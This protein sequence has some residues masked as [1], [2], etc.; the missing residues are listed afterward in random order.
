MPRLAFRVFTFLMGSFANREPGYESPGS[1]L[2]KA[3]GGVGFLEDGHGKTRTNSLLAFYWPPSGLVV[4][5]QRVI[6]RHRL[7]LPLFLAL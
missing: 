2:V 6:E 4:L 1:V 5:G 7:S 3:E